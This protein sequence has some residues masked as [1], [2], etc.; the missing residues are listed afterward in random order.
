M[1]VCVAQTRPIKGDISG[2][3]ANHI[4][5]IELAVSLGAGTLVF[6]E[7]SLTGYEPTLAK[8]LATHQGDE[9]LDV[10]QKLSDTFSITISVGIPTQADTGIQISMIIFQARLPRLT[11]SKQYLHP[12]EYPYFIPGQNPALLTALPHQM[13]PAICYESLVP[14]HAENAF[15]SGADIY[16]AS[17]AKSIGGVEK[18]SQHFPAIAQKYAMTVLMSNCVGPCDDFESIGKTSIWNNKGVLMGQ[19][20][21]TNEGIIL[22]DTVTE[23]ITKKTIEN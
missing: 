22:T 11:Y 18:A 21:E 19:M 7:L 20:N 6:P 10:F 3:I 9:R 23:E 13:A 16:L 4:K 17:V 8:A 2:N 15:K 1:K 14:P 5:L 12:D